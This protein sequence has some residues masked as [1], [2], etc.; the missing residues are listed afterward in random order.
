MEYLN[1][2]KSI[3]T[4]LRTIIY[5]YFKRLKEND[6]EPGTKTENIKLYCQNIYA[7]FKE[8]ISIIQS[9]IDKDDSIDLSM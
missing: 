3:M 2:L 6:G 7:I 1:V 8:V 9:V 5:K 4:N